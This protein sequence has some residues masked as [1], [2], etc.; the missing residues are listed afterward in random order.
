[1]FRV[2]NPATEETIAEYEAHDENE[3]ARRL[4]KAEATYR[5]WRATSF[6][7]RGKLLAATA[8]HLRGSGDKYAELM[9]REMG[10]PIAQARAEVE[11]CAWVCDYYAQEAEGI[12][13]FREIPTDAAQSGRTIRPVGARV[14]GDAVELSPLAGV[15]FRGAGAH[16]RQRGALEARLERAGL[17]PGD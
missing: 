14:G 5:S 1:M 7:E 10:K 2:I 9:T 17:G 8:E 13:A 3:I 4:E 11:K 15:S 16:G 6:A 12:L